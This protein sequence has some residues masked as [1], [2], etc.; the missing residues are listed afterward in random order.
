MI[1]KAPIAI[2]YVNCSLRKKNESVESDIKEIHESYALKI[3]IKER[4]INDLN[5]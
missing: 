2:F 4:K 5:N 1:V 3:D